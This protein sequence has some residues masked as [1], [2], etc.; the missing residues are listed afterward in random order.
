VVYVAEI[1]LT[2]QNRRRNTYIIK[3]KKIQRN[4]SYVNFW[5]RSFTFNSNKSPAGR[6][7]R[8]RTQHNYHHDTKVK[9]EVATAIIELLMMVGKTPETC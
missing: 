5:H 4:N 7:D 2:K 9:P 8:P 1:N 3:F 6:P